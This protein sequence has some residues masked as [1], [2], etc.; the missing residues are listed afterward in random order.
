MA[1]TI[2]ASS[3]GRETFPSSLRREILVDS[4]EDLATLPDDTS[5]G[6]VAFTADMQSMWMKDNAG[7]WKKIG[8]GS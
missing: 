8:G 4:Q 6:S 3:N 1:Y 5:P 2:I 7:G